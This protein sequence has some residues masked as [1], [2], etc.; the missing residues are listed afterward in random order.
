MAMP[1]TG[2]LRRLQRCATGR[3]VFSILAIDHRNNLRRALNPADPAAVS[4]EALVAFK[5]AV[6]AALAP[7]ASAVLVDPEYGAAPVIAAGV[8][9]GATGLILA[10]ERTGYTGERTAR[11]SGLLPGWDAQR[12]VRSGAD[13]VKLLVYYHPDAPTAPQIEA[14]VRQVAASCQ[15]AEIPLFLEPLSYSADP[16]QPRLAPQE[17]RRVVVETARRLTAIPG[18]DVLKA[19]FP[20]DSGDAPRRGGERMGDAPRRGGERVGDAPRRGGERVGDAPRRGC[21]RMGAIPD[22]AGWLDACRELSEASRVPWVL[23]SGGAD[24]QTYLH[25]AAAA[26]RAGASGVA[27]GRAVWQEATELPPEGRDEFLNTVARERMARVTALC[28]ALAR[29][30]GIRDQ[31]SEIG[32]Q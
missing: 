2:K 32:D 29:G 11:V 23:L 9:P 20:L 28:Q 7:A 21:E 6:V 31:R 17:R 16:A 27:V 24:F 25:Q 14:L 15:E 13:G 5:Q 10:L 4:D 30:I 12:A 1:S 22:E 26:A 18:V 3:G 19:E 8:L